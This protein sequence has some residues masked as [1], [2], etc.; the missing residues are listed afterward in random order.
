[1]A[2]P[3][4]EA[5]T[6]EAAIEIERRRSTRT[7]LNVR[8]SYTTVDALFTEFSRNVNEGGM[9]VATD[10]PPAIDTRVS[11][12]FQLPGR[13]EPIRASGRVAWIQPA[14]DDEPAGMGIEF[15][16]LDG[17]AREHIDRLIRELRSR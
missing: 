11:L 16:E 3:G 4:R 17:K 5:V 15:E 14:Q 13:A 9:F 12:K 2:A 1:M 10:N 7:P 8:V 6:D